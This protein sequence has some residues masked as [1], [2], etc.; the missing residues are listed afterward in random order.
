MRDFARELADCD[1]RVT[2]NGCC[3]SSTV[4]FFCGSEYEPHRDDCLWR[5]AAIEVGKH[6][7][8]DKQVCESDEDYIARKEREADIAKYGPYEPRQDVP[9]AMEA[10]MAEAMKHYYQNIFRPIVSPNW[11]ASYAKKEK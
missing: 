5:Q 6:V 1:P 8:E 7:P 9:T 4:C 10:M 2:Y 11:D 3:D